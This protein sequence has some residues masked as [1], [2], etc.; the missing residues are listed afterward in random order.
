MQTKAAYVHRIALFMKSGVEIEITNYLKR[1][2]YLKK[3]SNII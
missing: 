1:Y 3:S 2:V